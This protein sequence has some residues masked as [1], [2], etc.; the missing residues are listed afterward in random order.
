MDTHLIKFIAVLR[1]SGVRVSIAES[2]DAI[3]AVERLGV[4]NRTNFRLGLR[5]TLIKDQKD[6]QIFEE[7]FPIFFGS[8]GISPLFDIQAEFSPDEAAAIGNILQTFQVQERFFIERLLRG[9]ALSQDEL[10]RISKFTG[11][12]QADDLRYRVWLAKRLTKAMK[13]NNI[14]EA[15]TRLSVLLYGKGISPQRSKEIIDLLELNLAAVETYLDRYVGHRIAQNMTRVR[16][17]DSSDVLIYKSINSLTD[18]ELLI[19][20]DDVKR[21]ANALR[22]KAALRFRRAKSGRLDVKATIRANL[23]YGMVPIK[24]KLRAKTLKPKLV[25]LCD[26]ST[27]MRNYSELML[28]LLYCLQDQISRTHAFAFIDHLEYITPDFVGL[29][30]HEA[31]RKVLQKMPSGYYSTDLGSS[32]QNL[33]DDYLDMIDRRTTI[34]V[35]GDGRNN[36]NDPRTD[37]FKFLTRRSRQTM[38]ITPE[39]PNLWRTGDSDMQ[40][41][42][43][44]SSVVLQAGTLAELSA[45][46]DNFLIYQ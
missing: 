8:S 20:D 31:V 11:L 2:A 17:I 6:L 15:I 45:A 38:W 46:V 43:A 14:R 30:A 22:S 44:I 10:A 28:S 3:C 41:Y 37:V 40:L 23:I 21:L 9:D 1:T 12:S 29:G 19:L 5:S 13:I 42:A 16:E 4:K 7:L 32:L 25:V 34:I 35:V 33:Y 26:V 36:Y 27:S 39:N 18:K 24:L